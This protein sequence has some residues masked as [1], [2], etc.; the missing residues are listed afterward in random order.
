MAEAFAWLLEEAPGPEDKGAVIV[1]ESEYARN[2]AEKRWHPND[3]GPLIEKVHDLY[4]Q[5]KEK[6]P[7]EFVWVK[8]HSKCNGNC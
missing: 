1:Y 7:M 5:V 8:G 6:R 2:M 4:M 3:N